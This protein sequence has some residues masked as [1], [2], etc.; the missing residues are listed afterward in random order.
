MSWINDIENVVFTIITG[1][2]KEWAPKWKNAVKDI[3]YN[4]SVFEF[5][6]IEGSLALRQKPKGRKFDLEFYFDGEDAVDKGNNFEYSSR[7]SRAWTVKHPFYGNIICQPLSLKQD[8]TVLNVSKFSVP[9]IETIST[10]Y[11]K[12]TIVI[13]DEITSQSNAVN[14]SQA[15]AFE[16][17]KELNKVELIKN[18]E[19]LDTLYS[20]LFK[21]GEELKEFKAKV[22]DAV[23]EIT[24]TVATGVGIA[25]SVQ[26]VINYPSTIIQT[27]ESRFNVLK[28][29][30]QGIMDSFTGSKN[31]FELLAGGIIASMQITSS[32]NITDDY[33]TKKFVFDQ[34][35]RLSVEFN[36]YLLFLDNLQTE[37][38]D[39]NDSYT[40]NYRS[41]SALSSLVSLSIANLYE[42]AFL[43]KQERE[44]ILESDSN[45]ILLTHKYY[46][47][48]PDDVN[49]DKFVKTN[50]IGLNEILN[51]RKGRKIVYYV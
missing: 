5:V 6:N 18:I 41:I 29:S 19:Q 23:I 51:I 45:L 37:R 8:N 42:I 43:A 14:E 4:T 1:D 31:Q 17:S 48:D 44:Y 24:N 39:S 22:A 7:D 49:I 16:D 40:P 28:E 11:P 2:G 12:G 33:S 9:V 30:L 10:S 50:N 20:S 47:L 38:A 35:N 13:E 36:K 3:D 34:Q 26:A 46:G 15:Q 21:S 25:R 32:T 27:I